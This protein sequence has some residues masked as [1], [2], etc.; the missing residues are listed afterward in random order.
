MNECTYDVHKIPSCNS[1]W[2]KSFLDQKHVFLFISNFKKLFF[3]LHFD[4]FLLINIVGGI[5]YSCSGC[6]VSDF[7]GNASSKKKK[8]VTEYTERGTDTST[9]DVIVEWPFIGNIMQVLFS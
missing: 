5:L 4:I 2:I 7:I 3:Q 8:N 1:Q 6:T 9:E